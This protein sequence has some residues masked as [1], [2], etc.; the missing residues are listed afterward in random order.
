MVSS[1]FQIFHLMIDLFRK[2]LEQWG[3]FWAG[4]KLRDR[5]DLIMGSYNQKSLVLTI[6]NLKLNIDIDCLRRKYYGFYGFDE[7]F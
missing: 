3:G 7:E 4:G 2:L 6:R 1:I 5:F